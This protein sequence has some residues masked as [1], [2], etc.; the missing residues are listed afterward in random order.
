M[1]GNRQQQLGPIE[2]GTCYPLAVFAERS[3]LGRY[4]LTQMRRRGLRVIRSGGRAF[5]RGEDFESFLAQIPDEGE[6]LQ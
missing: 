4:A 2:S 1:A 5:V 3:G 6:K